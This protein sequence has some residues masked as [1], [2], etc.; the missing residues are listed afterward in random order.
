MTTPCRGML[1]TNPGGPGGS[2]VGFVT[3]EYPSLISVTGSNY[4]LVSWDPRGVVLSFPAI[5]CT[6]IPVYIYPKLALNSRSL[7]KLDFP[8][9]LESDFEADYQITQQ[10]G[11]A[12]EN[13]L[14][15]V[16]LT[17]ATT[18]R[19]MISIPD[20]FAQ[21]EDGKRAFNPLL[22]NYWGFSYGTVLGATFASMFPNRL[23][24]FVL[25]V[26]LDPDDYVSGLELRQVLL[27]DDVLSTFFLYCN[28][29][30]LGLCPFFHRK[31][32]RRHLSPIR[33][34][35]WTANCHLR[36]ITGLGQRQYSRF[37]HELCCRRTFRVYI[38]SNR[39]LSTP[40]RIPC[41]S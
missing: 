21:T 22:A 33:G 14:A 25:D 27:T 1:L 34:T 5:N 15:S 9:M 40:C 8:Q 19:D 10:E 23:G 11:Q 3:L 12:C 38:P 39:Q 30:G 18:A 31:H 32:T 41:E 2:G 16:H 24:H 28:K 20:A 4:D 29:A 17:T 37:L 7:P 26:V 13:D 35:G 6:G 36:G